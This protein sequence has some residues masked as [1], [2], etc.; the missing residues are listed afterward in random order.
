[1][2][3]RKSKR[4]KVQH[5]EEG[6]AWW[7]EA[8]HNFALPSKSS[9]VFSRSK[10]PFQALGVLT[11]A[12]SPAVSLYLLLCSLLLGSLGSLAT[13]FHCQIWTPYA[14]VITKWA[15]TVCWGPVAVEQGNCAAR[16]LDLFSWS[17]HLASLLE[18]VL[19]VLPVLVPTRPG[20]WK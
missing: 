11:S 14:W 6:T 20:G 10:H 18:P 2:L 7:D 8:I 9:A 16:S 15:L 12:P 4:K 3:W 17:S 5:L 1:M 19:S 13:Q